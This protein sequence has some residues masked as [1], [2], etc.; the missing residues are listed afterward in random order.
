MA[1][2]TALGCDVANGYFCSS[3]GCGWSDVDQSRL[4]ALSGLP[5]QPDP[6]PSNKYV[7]SPSAI[8]LGKL[9]F[10]ENRLGGLSSW[11][12]A[13]N[14]P[15]PYGRGT[16]GQPV[17]IGCVGCHDFSNGSVDSSTTPGD[18]SL[19]AGWTYTNALPVVNAAYYKIQLWNGRVDS[20]W[21]QAVADNENPLTN[22]G[23]RLQT[24]WFINDH[25]HDAYQA[26]FTD[27]PLPFPGTS[28]GW[29]S[30]LETSGA[31]AGQC[32]LVSGACP[33]QCQT[34]TGTAPNTATGCW[35]R[36][37]LQGKPGKVAGCQ[38]G[39]PTE[40]F[41][42]AF[43][44][45]D[46]ADQAAVTRV[47]V[48]FGKA[49]AAY[50]FT[51]VSGSSPFD[52]WMA[53]VT[54]GHAQASSAM[55]SDAKRGALLFVG[56][57]GCSDCHNGPMLSDSKFHNIGVAQYGPGIPVE[58]DCG[59]GTVC[60]CAPPS[61]GHVGPKNCLPWGARDG[62]DKLQHNAFRRDSMW[63]DDPADTSRMPY[64]N[65]SLDDSLKGEYRTPSLRGVAL[66]APY[67]HDGSMATLE[68]VV[69]HYNN[70]DSSDTVGWPAAQ[71]KPLYLTSDEQSDLVA[72]LRALTLDPLPA[73]ATTPPVLPP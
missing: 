66:T 62:I 64:V 37:P 61:T 11:Q 27:Y 30:M 29:Q 38:P 36:F 15:M 69:T 26:V 7:G 54:S 60:D 8:A 56:K 63:S 34:V 39:E 55:S 43:D 17:G 9:F 20:L 18:V 68:E 65:M 13:L 2:M 47:L 72:F 52:R 1:A 10:F 58:A 5:S 57:A 6:D 48:D 32:Q 22:N 51:L 28:D 71:L 44:C 49:V 41:G 45:M 46:P 67:M 31:L 73:D 24:A 12:D 59:A 33:A 53:D 23:N 19:G 70:A 3:N 35:P 50:E 21:A 4:A 16:K 25:Y 40:P 14:R 42:D